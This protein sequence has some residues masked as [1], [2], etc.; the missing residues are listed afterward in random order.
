MNT[1]IFKSKTFWTAVLSI[2]GL[3]GAGLTGTM[4]WSQAGPAILTALI[5]I[6]LK[7]GQITQAKTLEAKMRAM[8]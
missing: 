2:L 8:R 3:V 7:D 1:E 5:G 6:F 4:T